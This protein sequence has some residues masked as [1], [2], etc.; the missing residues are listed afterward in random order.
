MRRPRSWF[1][2]RVGSIPLA[3]ALFVSA[4]GLVSMAVTPSYREA[5]RPDAVG[6]GHVQPS[7]RELFRAVVLQH[8]AGGSPNHGAWMREEATLDVI[9][10][11]DSSVFARIEKAAAMEDRPAVAEALMQAAHAVAASRPKA[12]SGADLLDIITSTNVVF[13]VDSPVVWIIGGDQL[14]G[15]GALATGPSLQIDY[16]A[17]EIVRRANE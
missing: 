14:L 8:Q 13:L 16:L 10:R 3:G 5:V 17:D 6:A 1:S 2:A 4:L 11:A 15:I 7:G 12:R 9:A